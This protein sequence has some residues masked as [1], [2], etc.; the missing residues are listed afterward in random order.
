M[1]III[2][3]PTRN[4]SSS[5]LCDPARINVAVSRARHHLFILG[6]GRMLMKT[7]LW[8]SVVGAAQLKCLNLQELQAK[9]SSSL[10][11]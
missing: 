10:E 4:Q 2:I 3:L 5:F 1:D 7:P 6:N 11:T 8:S 9:L